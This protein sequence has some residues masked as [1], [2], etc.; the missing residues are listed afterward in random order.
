MSQR[1]VIDQKILKRSKTI[2]NKTSKIYLWYTN[3]KFSKLVLILFNT[4]HN[5]LN[6]SFKKSD[7][8]N[9]ADH[10]TITGTSKII[11][12]REVKTPPPSFQKHPLSDIVEFES[13]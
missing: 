5:D 10:N 3:T 2:Y 1:N 9:F 11:V 7:L 13:T 4:F 6:L 8:H 12:Y